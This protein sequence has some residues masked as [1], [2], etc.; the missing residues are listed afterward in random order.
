MGAA[1]LLGACGHAAGRPVAVSEGPGDEAI[2]APALAQPIDA[3]VI[4]ASNPLASITI[5][6]GADVTPA[7]VE[8]SNGSVA[9]ELAKISDS[10]NEK[11]ESLVIEDNPDLT[12]EDGI[13]VI[14]MKVGA[15]C[16]ETGRLSGL[17]VEK[18]SECVNG[19][20]GRCKQHSAWACYF[21]ST[22]TNH[23]RRTVCADTYGHCTGLR[24]VSALDDENVGVAP[25]VI[26]RVK[27]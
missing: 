13:A 27:K 2:R 12:D 14:R 15:W 5:D 20:K 26:F 4:D 22:R 19:L 18:Q 7:V 10:T 1:L 16:A 21:F 8:R 24:R 6:A 9:S 3:G 25:C 23:E 17:C 11:K